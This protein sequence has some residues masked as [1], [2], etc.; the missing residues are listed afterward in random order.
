MKHTGDK[1]RIKR[2]GQRWEILVD[3]HYIDGFGK[4]FK[5]SKVWDTFATKE[6]AEIQINSH[7]G[8]QQLINCG[9]NI[10]NSN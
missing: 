3:R 6:L 2:V 7:E 9:Y 8:K 10:T 1:I 5:A 4:P